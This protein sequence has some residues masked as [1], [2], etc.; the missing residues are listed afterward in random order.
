MISVWVSIL[1]VEIDLRQ[2]M[3]TA[4]TLSQGQTFGGR[5]SGMKKTSSCVGER[6]VVTSDIELL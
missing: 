1:A 5:S 3:L 2:P 6:G 4:E